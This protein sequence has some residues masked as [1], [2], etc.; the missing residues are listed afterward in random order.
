MKKIYWFVLISLMTIN[1]IS[2]YSQNQLPG[3]IIYGIDWAFFVSAPDEWIMDSQSLSKFNIFAL[4]YENGK[5]LGIGTPMIYINATELEYDNDE[6]MGKYIVWDLGEH[7]KNGSEII[8]V[9]NELNE[10]KDTYFIY[11]IENSSGQFETIIYRRYKGTCF[12]IIL[13]A[14]NNIVR[15]KLFSKMED[16]VNSMIFMDLIEKD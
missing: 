8:R 2:V 1:G 14:P 10:I 11:N 12:S 5:T 6:E 4:F 9:N 15:Q 13:N 3:G 16:I 7:N